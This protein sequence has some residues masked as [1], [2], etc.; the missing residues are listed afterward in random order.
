MRGAARRGTEDYPKV[1]LVW[2]GPDPDTPHRSGPHATV[3]H[4]TVTE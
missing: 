1:R 3:V 2:G 4:S